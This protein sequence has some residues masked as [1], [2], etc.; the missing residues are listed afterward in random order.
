[1]AV[2]FES[3]RFVV[4][5]LRPDELPT[6]QALYEANPDYFFTVGGQA[7]RP[8]EAQQEF[9][10]RPPAHLGYGSRWFAGI[11]D[12]TGRL[13]GLIILVSDLSAPQV[14]H[15]ALFFIEMRLRGTGAAG[16]IHASLEA[17][18][19][20]GGARWLRLGVV[21]GNAPAE[22]FWSKCGYLE[23]RT[24]EIEVA[25]GVIRTTR[26]MVKPLAGNTLDEYLR[27][28]P[29]DQPDSTQA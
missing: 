17:W 5:E 13:A 22:R 20:A 10:E 6:L 14:W 15:T 11:F 19:E 23:V 16:E 12:R 9:D 18:A 28:V 24:R 7:P 3:P 1:M 27:R 29:R 21:V 2:L 4:R 26:V 25:L 8:D